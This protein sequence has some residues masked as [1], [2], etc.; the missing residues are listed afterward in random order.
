M[1]ITHRL[2]RAAAVAT[3]ALA[4]GL[5]AF[6]TAP[7]QAS[8]SATPLTAVTGPAAVATHGT[9]TPN[10]AIL[11]DYIR[12]NGTDIGLCSTGFYYDGGHPYR[13]P[14]TYLWAY[15]A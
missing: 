10:D 14:V 3:T 1:T 5:G 6:A 2:R 13:W 9:V 15:A 8:S 7:A 11:C 12:E 4:I